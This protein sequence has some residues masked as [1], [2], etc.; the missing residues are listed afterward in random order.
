ML[1]DVGVLVVGEE[2]MIF[3]DV[4]LRLCIF[5][6][7]LSGSWCVVVDMGVLVIGEK[8]VLIE[9]GGEVF[10]WFDVDMG[11]LYVVM[12]M[13]LRFFVEVIDVVGEVFNGGHEVFFKGV[14]VEFVVDEGDVFDVVVFECGVGCM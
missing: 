6:L 3:L 12:F 11:N 1:V 10:D 9:V 13:S 8:C 4:G 5:V 7:G 14:N 2:I